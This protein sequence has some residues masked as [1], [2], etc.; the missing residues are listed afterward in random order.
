MNY[1]YSDEDNY[2]MDDNRWETEMDR[3]KELSDEARARAKYLADKKNQDALECL[4]DM[5]E[6]TGDCRTC[7]CFTD[8][9]EGYFDKRYQISAEQLDFLKLQCHTCGGM[10]TGKPKDKRHEEWRDHLWDNLMEWIE[11]SGLKFSTCAW[12]ENVYKVYGY[13]KDPD[14]EWEAIENLCINCKHFGEE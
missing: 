7:H 1:L 4:A 13:Y 10:G 8:L 14:E 2:P 3:A 9:A 11:G 5:L 6:L 12:C